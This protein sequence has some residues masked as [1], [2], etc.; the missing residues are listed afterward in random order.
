MTMKAEMEAI[1]AASTTKPPRL[2]RRTVRLDN[3]HRVGLS[4]CGEGVPLV[5]V[6]GIIAEG[7]LY[8]RTLRRLAGMGFRVIAVDSAGH[9]RTD[10]LGASGYRWRSY[11][12]L[13]REVL[14]HLGIRR[15]VF[16]G[17]SM[18]G[19]IVVDLA[20]AEPERALAVLPV[21]AAVGGRW[22]QFTAAA[23]F[24]PGLFP[25][26]IG[27]LAAD[28]AMSVVRGRRQMG[29]V[30]RLATPSL[31]DRAR[32]LPALPGAFWATL[33]NQGSA[34]R[35]RAL[36]DAGVPVFMLH[37]ARDLVIW[38]PFAR[39]AAKAADAMLVR[40]E[41]GRH[42]WLLENADTL[43]AIVRSLLDGPLGVALDRCNESIASLY[44]PE[45]IALTLDRPR[46]KP[47]E[48]TAGH[49]WRVDALPADRRRLPS[50]EEAA[51]PH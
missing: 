49:R 41:E 1:A 26:G 15:A 17:H 14:D 46:S 12:E 34:K 9:G 30:A 39:D 36:A 27:L 20:A 24:T 11:V 29:S 4:L 10:G 31:A 44:G 23:H 21:G 35:L 51:R 2:R 33:H 28:T 18:G 13:H 38:Y 3:G 6:H 25:L 48:I 5:M 40:V 19:R 32:S 50:T 47:Y 42:S 7:M 45:A 43:P 8:A 16:M 22:D 37:G